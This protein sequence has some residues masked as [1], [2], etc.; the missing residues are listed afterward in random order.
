MPLSAGTS[1]GV[2]SQNISIELLGTL[3]ECYLVA[4]SKDSRE[5]GGSYYLLLCHKLP[6]IIEEWSNNTDYFMVSVSGIWTWL[7]YVFGVRISHR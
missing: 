7:S 3:Q 2:V 5:P 1:A 6:Q 4:K